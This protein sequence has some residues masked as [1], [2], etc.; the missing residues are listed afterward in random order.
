MKIMV[1]G[2]AG[3][4]GQEVLRELRTRNI[5]C[6]GVSREDFD[7]TD[8]EA[9]LAAVTREAPDAII[10]CAAY[11]AVDKAETEPA[12]CCRVNAMGSLYLARAALAVRAKLCLISTDYVFSGEEEGPADVGSPCNPRSIYGLS[13]L[14]AEDAV[15]SIMT[16]CFIVR[17]A[18]LFGR[19]RCF[20]RTMLQLGRENA[21]VR[22]V[23]DQYGSPTY[24]PDLARFLCELI[25]TDRFGI[26]H[27]TNEGFCSRA[28]FAEEVFRAAGLNTAVIPVPSS[29]FPTLARRPANGRLSKASL[30][31]N[32]FQRLPPWQDAVRRWLA[33]EA[34]APNS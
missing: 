30:D 1:T 12:G 5:P 19:G 17:T 20:P 9:V 7:V 32:G 13:K 22:V 6:V 18:W 10:H 28:E 21:G 14:Q 33:E 3:Q 11:T 24:A 8:A 15:R 31:R 2:A 16:R 27:A 34:P 23:C 25:Q 29:A 4:L 26:Y